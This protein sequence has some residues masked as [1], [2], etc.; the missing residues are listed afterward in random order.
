MAKFMTKSEFV[1][2]VGQICVSHRGVE[3]EPK[4]EYSAEWYAIET[5]LGT[6][7]VNAKDNWVHCRFSD[8]QSA[9]VVTGGGMHP[10]G[11]WNFHGDDKTRRET[12]TTWTNAMARLMA[13]ETLVVN[14]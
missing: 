14:V 5:P 10:N 1:L 13:M 7:R 9:K 2:R 8:V 4:T 12:L 11:K 6:M 3:V